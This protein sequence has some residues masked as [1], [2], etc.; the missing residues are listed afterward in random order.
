[1]RLNIRPFIEAGV[2][3][4]RVNV[5]W[6]KDRGKDPEVHDEPLANEATGDLRKRIELHASVDR[7]N[8]L[9][10]TRTEKER[11]RELAKVAEG[12]PA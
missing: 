8:D 11:A 3:A 7:H 6:G 5:K 9:H 4:A 12:Q 1:M 2:L 10:F